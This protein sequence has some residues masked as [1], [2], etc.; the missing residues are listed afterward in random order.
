MWRNC[1][2]GYTAIIKLGFKLTLDSQHSTLPSR[3]TCPWLRYLSRSE[4][5]EEAPKVNVF[6][7]GMLDWQK[8]WGDSQAESPY[9]NSAG[10][11]GYSSGLWVARA[12]HA[13]WGVVWFSTHVD[14]ELWPGLALSLGQ[15]PRLRR[16]R[17]VYVRE[18]KGMCA[19]YEP[20]SIPRLVF[21]LNSALA[22]LVMTASAWSLKLLDRNPWEEGLYLVSL[23]GYINLTLQ[24]SAP[25]TLLSQRSTPVKHNMLQTRS[26]HG[27]YLNRSCIWGPDKSQIADGEIREQGYGYWEEK[28]Q[29][30]LGETCIPRWGW[31]NV[32]R[33]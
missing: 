29:V 17:R 23:F 6:L 13:A 12:C 18:S 24:V 20:Q 11:D 21:G 30:A 19:N 32:K 2:Q 7:F 16:P 5:R 33:K 4:S 3:L 10:G 25:I 14:V 27:K 9:L 8:S 15:W 1:A 28:E 26:S 31:R 22:S